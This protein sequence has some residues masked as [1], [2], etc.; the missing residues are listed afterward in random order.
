MEKRLIVLETHEHGL[1]TL[2]LG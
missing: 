1:I 2:V